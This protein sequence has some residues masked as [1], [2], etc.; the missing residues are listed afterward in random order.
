MLVVVGCGAADGG[1]GD[2]DGAGGDDEEEPRVLVVE[3]SGNPS[4]TPKRFPEGEARGKSQGSR[5]ILRDLPRP[6]VLHPEGRGVQNPRP[7]KISRAEGMDF[8]LPPE[9]WWSTDILSSLPGKDCS[10]AKM[11]PSGGSF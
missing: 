7:R 5:E 4:L 1:G 11:S 9:S 6:W 2:G 10:T 3:V 8:P